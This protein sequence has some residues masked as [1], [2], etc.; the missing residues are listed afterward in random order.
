MATKEV[1]VQDILPDAHRLALCGIC[2]A[3][4]LKVNHGDCTKHSIR[5]S[6]PISPV[7]GDITEAR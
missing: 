5:Y 4:L 2:G 6:T 7:P 1:Q 3:A